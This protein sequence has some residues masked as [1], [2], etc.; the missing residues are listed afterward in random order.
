M[1]SAPL[2]NVLA[3]Y[4]HTLDTEETALDDVNS[5][6]HALSASPFNSGSSHTEDFTDNGEVPLSLQSI[7]DGNITTFMISNI[8]HRTKSDDLRRRLDETG[9]GYVY[10]FLYMPHSFNSRTNVGYAFINF[11]SSEY[12]AVF[13]ARWHGSDQ[14]GNPKHGHPLLLQPAATQGLDDL[15][16]LCVRKK[17]H[18]F[19]NPSFRPFIRDASLLPAPA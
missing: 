11:D 2:Q 17:L 10:D 16:R 9:F 6:D 12:A 1:K 14:L 8:P 3:Q 19:R 7:L 15:L 4:Q 5:M 13:F 18:R